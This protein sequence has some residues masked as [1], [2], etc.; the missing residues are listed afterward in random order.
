MQLVIT[1]ANGFL[2]RALVEAALRAGHAVVA[3]V[4]PGRAT[5][6]AW[7]GNDRIRVHAVAL[8]HSSALVAALAGA[9]AV[10]H[11]AAAKSGDAAHQYE[12]TV[13][14]TQ[15]LLAA[16]TD[17]GVRRLIG[18]SSFAVYDT[19]PLAPGALLDENAP[20][21]HGAR[22]GDAY[23]RAKREQERLFAAYDG[24]VTILR[25]G[26]VYG[27]GKL[28]QFALGRALGQ[29][30][31]LRIGP[32]AEEL[33]WIYRDNCADAII[34]AASAPASIGA[35]INLVDDERPGRA[36]FIARL[37]AF[38]ALRRR[39]VP[40][41]WAMLI[42]CARLAEALDRPLNG[43][44]RR[45]GLLRPDILSERFKPLRYANARAKSLLNWQ[46]TVGVD[47]ALR[48][49]AETDNA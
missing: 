2:G 25:P 40:L 34:A 37:N 45:P 26:L 1:G 15:H 19:G 44:L 28:W 30:L 24:D 39:V 14:A 43:R 17:A 42:G 8:D 48:R 12:N 41:P 6:P 4:R 36:A 21:R 5:P 7:A 47:A 13:T 29:R 49:C 22:T 27:P 23:A 16:M 3:L 31:W 35:C 38:A 46:P 11:A 20:L 32:D 33:P 10:I 9:D 18:V